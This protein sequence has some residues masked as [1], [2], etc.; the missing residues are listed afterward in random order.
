MRGAFQSN[1]DDVGERTA[2]NAEAPATL[3]EG[4]R[5][6]LAHC[7]TNA[8]GDAFDDGIVSGEV[9]GECDAVG[10]A[11]PG[12]GL[13]ASALLLERGIRRRPRG[14]TSLLDA[15]SAA[16]EDTIAGGDAN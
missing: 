4:L 11:D 10:D 8:V 9:E 12:G 13:A 3:I 5:T 1:A 6:R 7:D 14:E 15:P 16:A 2:S